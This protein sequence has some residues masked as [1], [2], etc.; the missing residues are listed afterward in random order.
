[1][2]D[3]C[4]TVVLYCRHLTYS[5]FL[6]YFSLLFYPH[7]QHSFSSENY[8]PMKSWV[9]LILFNPVGIPRRRRPLLMALLSK[10]SS[11]SITRLSGLGLTRKYRHT[12]CGFNMELDLQSLFGL[13]V[14]SCTHWLRPRNSPPPPAIGLI[15][16][17]AIGQPR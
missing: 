17:G 6:I 5:I 14:H 10:V 7:P 12:Y 4:T 11:N 3:T 13:H 2:G 8:V 16:E 9:L 1:M 15:Y